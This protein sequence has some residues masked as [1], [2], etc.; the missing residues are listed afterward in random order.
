MWT[1]AF[2]DGERLALDARLRERSRQK[3]RSATK[4]RVH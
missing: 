1:N 2:H 4:G 3:R